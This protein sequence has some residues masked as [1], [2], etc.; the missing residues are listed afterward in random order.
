M[1]DGSNPPL[2]YGNCGLRN[3]RVL[4]TNDKR[5]W[6]QGL[7][8]NM[9]VS[10]ATGEFIFITDID[11]ILTREAIEA[12]RNYDGDRMVFPRY[13]AIL[14]RYGNLLNDDKSLAD[15]GSRKGSSYY[16]GMHGNTFAMKRSIFNQIGGYDKEFCETMFHAGRRFRSEEG[17]LL[18]K[19]R[20][21]QAKAGRK[22]DAEGPRVYCYPVGRYRKDWSRNPL[23]LFHD[24]SIEQVPQPMLK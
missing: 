10:Q 11:H 21:F 20:R 12:V 8:R 3:F 17:M 22:T 7:A 2:D 16:A 4:F 18:R 1:D 13:L 14:D 5:P 6:T 23:G 24:L 19:Y 15:F 9:G